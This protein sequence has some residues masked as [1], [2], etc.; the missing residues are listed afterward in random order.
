[1]HDDTSSS[2]GGCWSTFS[3]VSLAKVIP[4][5]ISMTVTISCAFTMGIGVNPTLHQMLSAWLLS[6]GKVAPQEITPSNLETSS[7]ID[8]EFARGE[9][10]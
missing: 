9:T 6:P 10:L 4:S 8:L 1:M 7:E 5:I 3:V 2:T